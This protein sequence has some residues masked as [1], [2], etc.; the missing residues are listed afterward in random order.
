MTSWSAPSNQGR[1]GQLSTS[2]TRGGRRTPDVACQGAGAGTTVVVVGATGVAVA[3]ASGVP[4]LIP[5]G[6]GTASGAGAGTCS[7][8]A[9]TCWTLAGR[10]TPSGVTGGV[11]SLPAGNGVPWLPAGAG[12]AGVVVGGAVGVPSIPRRPSWGRRTST[13]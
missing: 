8:P 3:G 1:R 6:A 4:W 9:G 10:G 13:A 12:V 2:C 7:T 5:S 11:P